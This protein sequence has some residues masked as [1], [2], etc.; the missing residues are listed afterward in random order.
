MKRLI[1]TGDGVKRILCFCALTAF[2]AIAPVRSWADDDTDAKWKRGYHGLLAMCQALQLKVVSDSGEWTGQ[3]PSES[4]LVV[5]GPPDEL[6][7]GLSR[8]L[9]RGGAVLIAN[10][11]GGRLP[12][13]MT[14]LRGPVEAARV[15]HAFQGYTDCPLVTRFHGQHPVVAGL[16]SVAT[17]RPGA[18]LFDEASPDG[19]QDSGPLGLARLPAVAFQL[20]AGGDERAGGPWFVA[21]TEVGPRGR[22][23][24]VAD[25]SVF[26]NQMLLYHDNLRLAGNILRWLAD[27]GRSSVL[28]IDNSRALSHLPPDPMPPQIPPPTPEEVR[29]ALENM[30]PEVLLDFG[31]AVMAAMEDE[32]IPNDLIRWL[33]G[34]IPMHGY[35]RLLILIPTV[36]VSALAILLFLSRAPATAPLAAS[37]V[38][39]PPGQRRRW[40]MQ[41]RRA[42]A[43]ELLESFR[44]ELS[45][46]FEVPWAMM[47]SGIRLEGQP[48]RTRQLRRQLARAVR[49]ASHAD[50]SYWSTKRLRQLDQQIRRWRQLHELGT[51]RIPADRADR[52]P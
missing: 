6:P 23:V 51:L 39:P 1:G 47:L 40:A 7:V 43:K 29:R 28:V 19:R 36:L 17:N 14:L 44:V 26:S 42:A 18:L 15:E 20:A 27:G 50:N 22:M 31:N 16:R 33:V 41:Q 45:G 9:R 11:R 24:V 34:R 4:L 52:N 46:S 32:A 30:P 37:T 38:A 49:Q 48:G 35:H 5:F 12:Q 3:S 8:Y 2:C 21:A 25:Q 13:G 10:D